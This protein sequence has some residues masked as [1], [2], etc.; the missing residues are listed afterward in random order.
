MSLILEAHS[1]YSATG[2]ALALSFFISIIILRFQGGRK[3]LP[4][5]PRGLPIIGNILQLP[6]TN[7]HKK[8]AEWGAQYGDVVYVKFFQQPVIVLNSARAAIELMEKRG[9][10]YS[11][12][13]RFIY[14]SDLAQWSGG[15]AWVTYNS[16]WKQHRKWLQSALIT[17]NTL[18]RYLPL[19]RREA[20]NLLSDILAN[21]SDYRNHLKRYT[22]AIIL[23]IAYGRQITTIDDEFIRTIEEGV[24]T[25]LEGAGPGG[26]LVDYLPALQ[27]LPSWFPGFGFTKNI[28]RARRAV[29][30]LEDIPYQRVKD[31]MI[32]GTARPSFVQQL[33][34]EHRDAGTLSEE[35]EALIK[36]TAG[37]MYLG[38]TD[39]S[40][41]SLLV[42]VLEMVL[43]PEI[44]KK[45][46]DEMDCALKAIRLPGLEDRSSLPYL[47]CVIREVYRI[48][49][50][51]QLGLPHQAADDDVYRGYHIPK[52]A[53][54]VAN[55]WAMT[56]DPD[57]F[58]D[59]EEFR[60]E[61]FLGVD[62]S[63]NE[64]GDP[65]QLVFGFGR[66]VCPGQHLADISN[67]L[68]I[69]NIVA[70]MDICK[71]RDSSG[72]EITPTPTFLS[73]TVSHPTPFLCDIH[74]RSAKHKELIQYECV[75][76]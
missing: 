61:R 69:A 50:A 65:K 42:F 16:I 12:R 37:I 22:A 13:P 57:V 41:T 71:A 28:A 5:G 60:P 49:P 72:I 18:D 51:A 47:E 46:H 17:R 19:Q 15:G 59:P 53:T 4:P 44:L 62:L 36:S 54:V 48:C 68:A 39:T 14:L 30:T 2:V 11:G 55:I 70:T 25:V 63:Q 74:P 10:K 8:Y 9:A 21:P 58:V 31:E 67:W 23:E 43:H 26:T 34:E 7:Q 40:L 1:Y 56:R 52:G 20:N 76:K 45:L 75:G 64:V 38:G 32:K 27:Y 29:R 3:G 33:V 66:R 24:G 6:S 35:K 73:G